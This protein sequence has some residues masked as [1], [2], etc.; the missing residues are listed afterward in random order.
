LVRRSQYNLAGTFHSRRSQY[1]LAGTFHGRRS[2]LLKTG[3]LAGKGAENT[4]EKSSSV[5]YRFKRVLFSQ[6]IEKLC[7]KD[8]GLQITLLKCKHLQF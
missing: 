3:F 4:K 1:N 8:N 2:C 6:K 7:M 5:L